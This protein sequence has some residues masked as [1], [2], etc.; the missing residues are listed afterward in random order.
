[1]QLEIEEIRDAVELL[2]DAGGA[3][4][5]IVAQLIL[6]LAISVRSNGENA[7]M[8]KDVVRKLLHLRIARYR[9]ANYPKSNTIH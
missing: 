1:M 6:D 2:A 9:A 4:A 3:E 8:A 5:R 7:P